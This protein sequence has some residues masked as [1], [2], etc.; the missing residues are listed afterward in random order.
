MIKI[1]SSTTIIAVMAVVLTAGVF[2]WVQTQAPQSQTAQKANPRLFAFSEDQVAQ[3][4]VQTPQQTIVLEHSTQSF[5]HSW[6]MS[7]PQKGPA[8]E[9]A[10][11]YLL[12]LL[13]TSPQSRTLEI[14]A[15]R[16][17]EFG[18]PS[19][20]ATIIVTLANQ[21]SHRLILGGLDPTQEFVYA[22]V[23]PQGTNTGSLTLS[24]LP[25]TFLNA[26]QRPL[27]E[28]QAPSSSPPIPL[29]TLPPSSAPPATPSTADPGPA[30]PLPSPKLP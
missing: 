2:V 23:D 26:I 14:K 12:N 11:A 24:L 29:T 9:A 21:Q 3:L 10:I 28:W 17:P 15:E 18:F 8:D 13:I 30:I 4:Q 27:S 7:A 25:K 20:P 22:Q 5:P 16:Q 1:K 6:L 19:S